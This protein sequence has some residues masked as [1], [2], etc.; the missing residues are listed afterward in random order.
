MARMQQLSHT[1]AKV[2]RLIL[3]DQEPEALQEVTDTLQDYFILHG[4]DLIRWSEDDFVAWL[5]QRNLVAEEVNQLAYFIDEY[6]GLQD[7]YREQAP[8]Y[9]KLLRLYDILEKDY[10]FLS[11]EHLARKQLLQAQVM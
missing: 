10:G 9:R 4:V 2:K 5:R 3:D 6:A 11:F 1:L 8:V 7:A